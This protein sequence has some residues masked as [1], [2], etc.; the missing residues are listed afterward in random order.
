MSTNVAQL[1]RAWIARETWGISPREDKDLAAI[2]KAVLICARGDGHLSPIEREWM[3]GAYAARGVS[4]ELIDELRA[5]EG[6]EDLIEVLESTSVSHA[7]AR[8]VLYLAIQVCSA[9]GELHE[10]ELAAIIKMGA[11]LGVSAEVVRQLNALYQE[12]QLLRQKRIKL[13]FPDGPPV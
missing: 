8:V 1:A 12:E 6:K 9:D 3:L 5:Y 7:A 2:A 11:V 13:A 4:A 10:L